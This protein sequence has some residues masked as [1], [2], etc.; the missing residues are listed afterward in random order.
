MAFPYPPKTPLRPDI[1][2][3]LESLARLFPQHQVFCKREDLT[4]TV[5]SGNKIRKLEFCAYAALEQKK[6]TLVTVGGIQSNHARCTAAVAAQLGLHCVLLLR[7]GEN[8]DKPEGNLLLDRLLSAEIHWISAK[9]YPQHH[10]ALD[11]LVEKLQAQGRHPYVVAEGGSSPL[12]ALG[13]LKVVE[14]LLQQTEPFDYIV[15][16]IGSGG[17][18]AG[19]YAGTQLFC[20]Q[21]QVYGVTAYQSSAYFKKRIYQLLQE[22]AKHYKTPL[23]Q[24]PDALNID[25]RFVGP[26]YA[27]VGAK[28]KDCIRRIAAQTGLFLDP[29][30]TSKAFLGLEALVK[31]LPPQSRVLFLHTGGIFGLMVSHIDYFH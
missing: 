30:Y 17:T 13:Y 8:Q 23:P 9:E 15:T 14:E 7:E 12:G 26:G 20:P 19:L 10:K 2:T 3:P 28:E 6:D 18:F 25:D 16:A 31:T 27:Q 22:M 5:L 11:S 29:A 24:S 21:T 1:P 4:G